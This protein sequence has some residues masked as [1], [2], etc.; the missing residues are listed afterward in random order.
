M[1]ATRRKLISPGVGGSLFFLCL[2][3]TA[4]AATNSNW[5]ARPWQLEDGL[6]HNTVAGIAQ[7]DDGFLW[8]GSPSGLA[9]F[10]GARFQTFNLTNAIFRGNRGVVMMLRSRAGGLWL[11]LNRGAIAYLNGEHTKV[12]TTADGLADQQVYKMIEAGDGTLW[13]LF[14]GQGRIIRNGKVMDIPAV[15]K[16]PPGQF[17]SLGCDLDGNIWWVK[18]GDLG[19]YREDKFQRLARVG[20][21]PVQLAGAKGGGIWICTAGHLFHCTAQGAMD[22]RGE[23]ARDRSPGETTAL[24][25]DSE[26]AVWMGTAF[27]GLF[28]YDG[29]AFESIST[30]RP[31]IQCLLEDR[32]KSIWAGTLG[33][34]LNRIRRRVVQLQGMDSGRPFESVRS[35]SED[36][37]GTLWATT[38]N[39]TLARHSDAGWETVS[40]GAAWADYNLTCLTLD[41]HGA[42]WIGGRARKLLQWPQGK[43]PV[44]AQSKQLIG[45]IFAI[46]A[47]RDGNLWLGQ[48]GAVN[49]LQCLRD[50]KVITEKL[51]GDVRTIRAIAQDS[52]G[53]IWI[54][55]ARGDLLRVQGDEVVRQQLPESDDALSI[56]CLTPT[57]DGAIWVGYERLGVG[58]LKNGSYHRVD[59]SSGL[60]DDYIS[61]IV[62]DDNGWLWFGSDHGIFKVR[63]KDFDAVAQGK[64]RKVESIHYG[65]GD[66]V[67]NLQANY[68]YSPGALRAHDGRLWIPTRSGLAMIDPI[69]SGKDMPLPPVLIQQII[70]DEKTITRYSSI[71]EPSPRKD[72]LDLKTSGGA[73]RLPPQYRQLEIQFTTL[74]FAG[75]DNIRFHYRLQGFDQ[76]WQDA[77]TER[78]AKY[79][80]L[81]AGSYHFEVR[82]FNGEGGWDQS[83]ATL[84]F[85]VLPY[86]WQRWW[87]ITPAILLVLVIVAAAIRFIEKRRIQQQLARLKRERAVEH[88]RARIARDIHDDLGANLTEITLLSELA[89]S[90][91]AP[92]QEV[93]TDVKRIAAK[94]RALTH[95]LDEIVWAVN[96][97]NDT[98][99]SFVTYACIQAEEY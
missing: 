69:Q 72:V 7:T 27:G 91:D 23:F 70:M 22:D 64:L 29:S 37:Q 50:G 68:G 82:A 88:E 43:E 34:G 13:A 14:H 74:S 95:S 18:G 93:Q 67:M 48:V 45:T 86:F 5:F 84:D 20:G 58:W 39:G 24:L 31:E 94:A 51:P 62:S 28:R 77:G 59:K 38:E 73:L 78:H 71:A 53:T 44:L 17:A 98:L 6:P 26:G 35:L 30:S 63:R 97:R 57:D 85:A 16:L 55:S 8:L 40:N 19:V 32:E 3:L 52:Q 33:G 61:Q 60:F 83:G 89:Q 15:D 96:P 75:V 46:L 47:G 36:A 49:G 81:S 42:L 76:D 65:Q 79:P 25:E 66:G 21:N 4:T 9:S 2:S 87:F 1:L 54:G 99:D 12:F 56:R 80:R 90:A 41:S 11:G 10:D 92:V